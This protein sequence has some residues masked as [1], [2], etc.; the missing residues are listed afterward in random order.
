MPDGFSPRVR[1]PNVDR[2][3]WSPLERSTVSSVLLECF[4][5]L[6]GAAMTAKLLNDQPET[7]SPTASPSSNFPVRPASFLGSSVVGR[8]S[9]IKNASS[10]EVVCRS[11]K[12]AR[13]GA[14]IPL[15]YHGCGAL[16]SL[17]QRLDVQ[18]KIEYQLLHGLLKSMMRVARLC[19]STDAT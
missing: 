19:A 8:S 3:L 18:S 11:W 7:R 2:T 6:P 1:H 13:V 17:V 4:V 5:Q 14:S 12:V 15:G 9:F 10:V 16:E